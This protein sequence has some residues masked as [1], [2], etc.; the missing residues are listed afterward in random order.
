MVFITAHANGVG[1]D[2]C[3]MEPASVCDRQTL[4]PCPQLAS[5]IA[6]AATLLWVSSLQRIAASKGRRK[7]SPPEMNTR[8][9]AL[10][11]CERRIDPPPDLCAAKAAPSASHRI[12]DTLNGYYFEAGLDSA[13]PVPTGCRYAS[14][15]G[16][17]RLWTSDNHEYAS[18]PLCSGR[19]RT[20]LSAPY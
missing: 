5:V 15:S 20:P 4:H 16:T 12:R 7:P 11:C 18:P 14:Q 1:K 8:A 3:R 2:R 9:A 19:E 10:S 17:A 6:E 13:A